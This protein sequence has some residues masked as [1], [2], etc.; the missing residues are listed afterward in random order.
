MK[1]IL[2][3]NTIYSA[4]NNPDAIV[5]VCCSHNVVAVG[6]NPLRYDASVGVFN[7]PHE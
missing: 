7:P 2:F 1:M 3:F 4:I 5:G 6:F